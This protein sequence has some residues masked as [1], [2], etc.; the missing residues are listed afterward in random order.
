MALDF[1]A[2]HHTFIKKKSTLAT[3]LSLLSYQH[4]LTHCKYSSRAFVT[5]SVHPPDK[6]WWQSNNLCITLGPEQ[7]GSPGR[8]THLPRFP[9]LAQR[10]ALPLRPLG[11]PDV[12]PFLLFGQVGGPLLYMTNADTRFPGVGFPRWHKSKRSS[13]SLQGAL[14]GLGYCHFL[15]VASPPRGTDSA[16]SSAPAAL[17][18]I[19]NSPACSWH[20]SSWHPSSGSIWL[21]CL[22]LL[23]QY[24]STIS[25]ERFSTDGKQ[26]ELVCTLKLPHE[27]WILLILEKYNKKWWCK[28]CCGNSE[29]SIFSTELAQDHPQWLLMCLLLPQMV[30][31]FFN[32]LGL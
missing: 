12:L 26:R 20:S 3:A 9:A 8:S 22:L 17:D 10:Q 25:Y 30:T 11:I 24:R 21:L 6:L 13:D 18:Q 23:S 19:S 27:T 31:H 14:A 1:L 7:T 29:A 16:V 4:L 5:P 15:Q 28:R 2:A 32:F